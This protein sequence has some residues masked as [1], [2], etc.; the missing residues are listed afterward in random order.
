MSKCSNILIYNKKRF[1]NMYCSYVYT[2]T[3]S[4]MN[5]KKY[6]HK[7]RIEKIEMV[8]PAAKVS[9]VDSSNQVPN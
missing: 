2:Q 6:I 4:G 1:L 3:Q 9:Y 8:A 5:T 7:P